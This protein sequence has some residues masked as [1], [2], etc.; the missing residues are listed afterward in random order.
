MPPGQQAED[1]DLLS[2]FQEAEKLSTKLAL[3]SERARQVTGVVIGKAGCSSLVYSMDGVDPV[4]CELCGGLNMCPHSAA[5]TRDMART[6]NMAL[7]LD[8]STSYLASLTAEQVGDLIVKGLALNRVF[9]T[10]F[11]NECQLA[12]LNEDWDMTSAPRNMVYRPVSVPLDN[13]KQTTPPPYAVAVHIDDETKARIS[14]DWLKP[15]PSKPAGSCI[16]SQVMVPTGNNRAE[17]GE[18]KMEEILLVESMVSNCMVVLA[19]VKRQE[20]SSPGGSAA[21]T[22]PATGRTDD[23]ATASAT[24]NA[25]TSAIPAV[26]DTALANGTAAAG[27]GVKEGGWSIRCSWCTGCSSQWLVCQHAAQLAVERFSLGAQGEPA[28]GSSTTP[29]KSKGK[30]KARADPKGQASVDKKSVTKKPGKNYAK[31]SKSEI[32]KVNEAPAIAKKQQ[33]EN[34]LMHLSREKIDD[35]V[36][37]LLERGQ[38][39]AVLLNAAFQCCLQ[40]QLLKPPLKPTAASSADADEDVVVIE[41]E[42]PQ[43]HLVQR[44]REVL[45]GLVATTLPSQRDVASMQAHFAKTTKQYH[46][47][48]EQEQVSGW[49][50]S[51]ADDMIEKEKAHLAVDLLRSCWECFH[52]SLDP[53]EVQHGKK[54]KLCE[55]IHKA[56]VTALKS[57]DDATIIEVSNHCR[58]LKATFESGL[59]ATA[60]AEELVRRGEVWHTRAFKVAWGALLTVTWY[61]CENV[62]GV[63]TLTSLLLSLTQPVP[64][65]LS[66]VEDGIPSLTDLSTIHFARSLIAEINNDGQLPACFDELVDVEASWSH[67]LKPCMRVNISLLLSLLCTNTCTQADKGNNYLATTGLDPLVQVMLLELFRHCLHPVSKNQNT[68][69]KRN[70][71]VP[72]RGFEVAPHSVLTSLH[73][74]EDKKDIMT[75]LLSFILNKDFRSLVE[76]IKLHY[77]SSLRDLFDCVPRAIAEL[78]AEDRASSLHHGNHSHQRTWDIMNCAKSDQKLKNAILGSKHLRSVLEA[79]LVKWPHLQSTGNACE[80]TNGYLSQFAQLVPGCRQY[81]ERV[82]ADMDKL[83]KLE[84][85]VTFKKKASYDALV[86]GVKD[87]AIH[88]Q[89]F[90]NPHGFLTVLRELKNRIRR[91]ASCVKKLEEFEAKSCKLWPTFSKLWIERL[92]TPESQYLQPGI[93][94][95]T[96]IT[97]SAN[98]QVSSTPAEVASRYQSAGGVEETNAADECMAGRR[99]RPAMY[100]YDS[101]IDSEDSDDWQYGLPDI[102]WY[103]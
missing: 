84:K 88:Y 31:K 72:R 24:A 76:V 64:V 63:A 90:Q 94:I 40:G 4:Q 61:P 17:N 52:K 99:K 29:N 13:W 1:R 41:N 65:S 83:E 46:S 71:T 101:E 11:A 33:E 19:L 73:D 26:R 15:N 68:R 100:M 74:K 35:N 10:A 80:A 91:K 87:V 43:S 89:A 49:V 16:W 45:E 58:Q 9:T 2:I 6:P 62:V 44:R 47:E 96:G 22:A 48:A 60:V 36:A 81:I 55:N 23:D 3:V 7:D 67:L 30:G 98:E 50:M 38:A 42:L 39:R 93:T 53:R 32:S 28:T 21:V 77:E 66:T 14:P 56:M 12:L 69:P 97:L 79:P 8:A 20:A 59:Y 78:W 27:G 85:A 34:M 57:C 75:L 25:S 54:R 102:D 18:E 5:L 51:L 37:L 82:R 103:Y 70:Q 86:E 92:S 95:A